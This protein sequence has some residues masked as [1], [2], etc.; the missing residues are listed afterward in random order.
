MTGLV[1]PTALALG[2]D[3]HIY[4]SSRFEGVVYKVDDSG[5]YE[6]A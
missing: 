3:G 1:N 4:V 2:P 6:T 5:H